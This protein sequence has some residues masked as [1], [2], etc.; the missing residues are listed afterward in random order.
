MIV[1]LAVQKLWSLI[2]SHLSILA[3]VA[4]VFGV[5]EENLG[6]TIQDI[7]IGKDFMMKH[8]KLEMHLSITWV[9]SKIQMGPTPRP[10]RSE[11]PEV[12]VKNMHGF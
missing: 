10:I 11:S 5:S 1:Y 9:P 3:F 8:F 12:G 6:K 4:N 7:G 2:R